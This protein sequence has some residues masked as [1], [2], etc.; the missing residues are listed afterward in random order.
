VSTEGGTK[1][2]LAA[3]AANMGIAVSKFVAFLFTGSSSM[4]SEAIHSVADSGNQ[5]LLLVGGK[6]AGRKADAVHQFGYSRVRYVYAFVVSIV[7]FL[8]GGLFSLYEGFHKFHHPEELRDV[9]IA[10][11]VLLIA[12]LLEAFS[13]RTALREA[14]KSRAGRTLFRYVRDARQPELP[15]VLLEDFGALVGL[16]F[17]LVGVGMATVTGDSRWDGLGAM[18]VGA[19]LVVIAVFLAFEMASM[20][21]GESALPEQEQAI[22]EALDGTEL[23]DRVIHMRTLHVGPDEL[24]VAIKV[25]IGGDDSASTIAAGID[26][27]E[28]AIREAVPSARYIYIEPDLDR[29][30][31]A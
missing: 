29:A 25:A 27:A 17:A 12:I 19:L 9:G 3:M 13:F 8:V 30:P 4:L 15:V 6:R 7:L 16:M 20:L 1:A 18:A 2:V 11:G 24:L 5:V 21:V 22:T 31:R 23:I 10:I 26:E 14:R 28:R